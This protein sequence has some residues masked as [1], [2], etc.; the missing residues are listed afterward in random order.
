MSTAADWRAAAAAIAL[1]LLTAAV[2]KAET[3]L[4]VF[5]TPLTAECRDV[6][7]RG[8]RESYKRE[9]IEVV[10]KVSPQ[11]LSGDEKD[12]KRL[13]Y[14]ISTEQQMPVLGYLPSAQVTTDVANG[15]IAIQNS[16]HHGEL[17]FRYLIVPTTGNGDLKA[18]LESSRAQFTLL[19]PKQ[20]LL[21]AGTIDRGYGVYF[22]LQPS[23]QDTLQKQRELACLFD[24]PL[25]WR[26]DYVTI[27]CNS[28]G[29]KHGLGGLIDSEVACGA[30]LLCVGLYK[31]EDGE[32][33]AYAEGLAR[34]QQLYFN[35]VVVAQMRTKAAKSAGPHVSL[36]GPDRPTPGPTM[37]AKV[38]TAAIGGA[39]Q[40]Q[41]EAHPTE[42][43]EE[44]RA[45]CEELNA[46]KEELR[47]MNGKKG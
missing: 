28:K 32:A 42:L 13:H 16:S 4:V 25:Q 19:A 12:L 41:L 20:L 35:R 36:A 38:I 1:S 21:A 15:T 14:E 22:D 8:F 23:T 3:P 6:T 26:A 37:K 45:A 40:S 27:R 30:G 43:P 34:K 31:Q 29:T 10:F 46:A 44:A 18:D 5:D 9:V 17:S 24:V 2:A 7:P 39:V 33:R 11:L 47:K